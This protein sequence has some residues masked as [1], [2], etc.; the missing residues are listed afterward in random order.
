MIFQA[1][2]GIKERELAAAEHLAR[3]EAEVDVMKNE[4]KQ[5]VR[6]QLILHK[7]YTWFN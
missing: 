6:N 7:S 1:A 3:L 2:E 4:H 5:Q